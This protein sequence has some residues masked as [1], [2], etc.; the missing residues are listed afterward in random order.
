[1]TNTKKIIQSLH[2][3][4]SGFTHVTPDYCLTYVTPDY[5]RLILLGLMLC[6]TAIYGAHDGPAV[7]PT[8]CRAQAARVEEQLRELMART[9][10][11]RVERDS[12]PA[13]VS[14]VE[15]TGQLRTLE[16]LIRQEQAKLTRLEGE[17]AA[18]TAVGAGAEEKLA[19]LRRDVAGLES[20]ITAQRAT[21]DA[22]YRAVVELKREWNSLN[23]TH[24][25]AEVALGA[26]KDR[27]AGMTRLLEETRAGVA[28]EMT[29]VRGDAETADADTGIDRRKALF[30]ALGINPLTGALNDELLALAASLRM[31]GVDP[32]RERLLSKAQF[33]LQGGLRSQNTTELVRL[34]EGRMHEVRAIREAADK[35]AVGLTEWVMESCGLLRTLR[36]LGYM[37]VC[38]RVTK[39]FSAA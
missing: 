8:S 27:L 11:L 37:I 26:G 15:L 1:M 25:V 21:L 13:R 16:D 34:I 24:A 14:S 35:D 19:T 39:R 30:H 12:F 36:R 38:K 10:D 7:P 18:H 28:T 3:R 5:L 4:Q 32:E 23:L 6:S 29:T 20:R 31:G 17:A 2:T 33:E 22:K 9:A